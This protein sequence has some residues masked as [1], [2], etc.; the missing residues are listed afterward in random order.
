MA[1]DLTIPHALLVADS[2]GVRVVT[3]S[4]DFP[5]AWDSTAV[6]MVEGFGPR[7]DG[8]SVPAAVAVLPFDKTS[9][10]VIQ[11]ADHAGGL[12]FRLLI[13]NRKLYDAISDPFAVSEAYPPNWSARDSLPPLRWTPD[14]T[15]ARTVADVAAVLHHDGPLLLGATQALVDGGRVALK[16][17]APDDATIRRIWQLL[18]YSTRNELAVATFAFGTDPRFQFSVTPNPPEKMPFG[19]LSEENCRDVPEGRYE[20]A[21]QLAAESLNQ[22]EIDRLFLRRS[23][24]DTLKLALLMV[25]VALVALLV[26]KLVW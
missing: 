1:I 6:R 24:K 22:A 15:P 13:L 10:A 4:D 5:E 3:R 2:S 9:T 11:F 16:R 23:S 17:E 20:L 19:T 25:G 21:L 12:A 18:P 8:V 26:S 14:P 7:P